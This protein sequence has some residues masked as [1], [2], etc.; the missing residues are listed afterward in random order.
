MNESLAVSAIKSNPKLFYTCA[1]NNAKVIAKIGPLI[2][3]L[4]E[5]IQKSLLRC[6]VINTIAYIVNLT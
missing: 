3:K 4:N 2:K 5:V 6:Y 1:K